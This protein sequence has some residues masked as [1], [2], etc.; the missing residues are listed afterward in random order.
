MNTS[1]DK[2][3]VAVFAFVRRAGVDARALSNDYRVE[4][5]ELR[6]NVDTHAH[7]RRARR[8]ARAWSKVARTLGDLANRIE[9]GE[10][11][12]STDPERNL[13][14][15]SQPRSATMF[16]W[17]STIRE[18]S[19]TDIEALIT[20]LRAETK[21]TG[22]NAVT[23]WT[24]DDV[25]ALLDALEEEQRDNDLMWRNLSAARLAEEKAV[26]EN[27]RLRETLEWYAKMPEYAGGDA[28]PGRR[29]REA[30]GVESL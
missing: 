15:E 19:P 22:Q 28:D 27:K 30:L 6:K 9:R 24:T 8:A 21:S 25:V 2:E 26:E 14:L 17:R 12:L 10:H 20:R 16:R 13:V 7:A 5:D 18:N 11:T 3:R 23:R 4:H 29:A 1:A